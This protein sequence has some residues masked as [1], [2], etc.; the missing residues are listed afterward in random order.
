MDGGISPGDQIGR[1]TDF[2]PIRFEEDTEKYLLTKVFTGIYNFLAQVTGSGMRL[3]S[4]N[5][6]AKANL[7]DCAIAEPFSEGDVVNEILGTGAITGTAEGVLDM[8]VKKSG[9]T[10]GLTEG[11]IEQTDVTVKVNFGA[12]RTAIF[13]DQLIAGP[14]SKGGDS[15]SVVLTTGNDVVGLLFAGSNTTTIINRIQNVF[16]LLGITLA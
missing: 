9:R 8:R 14:M 3:Y 12:G 10:T 16:D 13:A 4:K 6:R 1:L 7:V 2:V 5:T 15:G 11:T